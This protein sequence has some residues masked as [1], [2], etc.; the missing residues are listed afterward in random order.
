MSSRAALSRIG[1]AQR[2]RG[3]LEKLTRPRNQS[4]RAANDTYRLA[5]LNRF[6]DISSSRR[7]SSLFLR[8]NDARYIHFA[9]PRPAK[10]LRKRI[11]KLAI[12]E[13]R[14]NGP[15]SITDHRSLGNE[16]NDDATLRCATI[17]IGSHA[18]YLQSSF[19][20]RRMRASIDVIAAFM[21]GFETGSR[22]LFFDVMVAVLRLPRFFESERASLA[23]RTISLR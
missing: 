19:C 11:R 6:V 8:S 20:E 14:S 7:P 12:D 1:F 23:R 2:K 17:P 5:G 16:Y 15:R 18:R 13:T 3:R 9:H 22:R 4:L 21:P 10:W